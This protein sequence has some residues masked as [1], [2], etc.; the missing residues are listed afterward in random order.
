MPAGEQ[1]S[2]RSITWLVAPGLGMIAV[3]YGLARFA[4]GLFLPEMREAFDLS[5]SILGLI[6]AGSYA[7]YCV[8]I[9]IA[10]MFTSRRAAFHGRC[11]RRGRG[12][13]YGLHCRCSR[14]L[15]PTAAV[16]TIEPAC[17]PLDARRVRR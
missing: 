2:G 5:E 13:R 7:G 6:G 17:D 12:G 9:L 1:R 15:G 16:I 14:G 11:R 8:T 4:Y 3:T 10:L